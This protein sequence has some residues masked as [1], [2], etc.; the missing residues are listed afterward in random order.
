MARAGPLTGAIEPDLSRKWVRS[1]TYIGSRSAVARYS[2]VTSVV[3][4]Y[5]PVEPQDIRPSHEVGDRLLGSRSRLTAV[6]QNRL[7]ND[8]TTSAAVTCHWSLVC[9]RASAP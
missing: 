7:L 9:K 1:E 6:T 3:L 4:P 5:A 8:I 2:G